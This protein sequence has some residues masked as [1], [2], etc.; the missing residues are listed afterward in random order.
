MPAPGKI[1]DYRVDRRYREAKSP[2][3]GLGIE[4]RADAA[5]SRAVPGRQRER[6][7]AHGRRQASK[8]SFVMVVS[9]L[10]VCYPEVQL[11]N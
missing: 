2:G 1:E 11:V 7:A 9:F 8:A 4:V 5:R 6:E 10:I 3:Y